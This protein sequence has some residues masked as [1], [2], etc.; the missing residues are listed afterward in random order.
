MKEVKIRGRELAVHLSMA[1]AA[2]LRKEKDHGGHIIYVY[3]LSDDQIMELQEYVKNR[4]K[5]NYF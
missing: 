2:L 5:R 1:G 4:Q 3:A